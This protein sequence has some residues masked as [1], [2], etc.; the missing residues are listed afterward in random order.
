M[1]IELAERTR[2]SAD[3][4]SKQLGVL[5]KAGIVTAGRNRLYQLQPQFIADK[6]ERL[7]DFGWCLLR[8]NTGR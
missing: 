2:Q 8:M 1:V 6:A 4:A 3:S 7:V 5:R